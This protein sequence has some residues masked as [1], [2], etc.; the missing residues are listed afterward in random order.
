MTGP[1][2]SPAE[3]GD[4]TLRRRSDMTYHRRNGSQRARDRREDTRSALPRSLV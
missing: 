1:P 3:G 2:R 4:M